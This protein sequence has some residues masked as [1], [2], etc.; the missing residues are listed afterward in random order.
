MVNLFGVSFK[1]FKVTS[2]VL[3]GGH[4]SPLLFNLLFFNIVFLNIPSCRL[5]LF[6]DDAKLFA[7]INSTNYCNGLQSLINSFITWCNMV[8]L[9]LNVDKIKI[10]SL[11]WSRT[12]IDY[13][14][15]LDSTYLQRVFKTID[16]EFI[17]SPSL[18]IRSLIKYISYK[19]LRF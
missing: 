3:K 19:V 13:N 11:F 6:A 16:L 14:Y 18:S 10:I 2:G 17:Y 15:F 12:F 7:R 4:L 9:T 8:G 1:M 5:L